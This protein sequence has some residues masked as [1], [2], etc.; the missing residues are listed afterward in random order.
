MIFSED[1]LQR[2]PSNIAVEI[3]SHGS[4]P[5]VESLLID[6]QREYMVVKRLTECSPADDSDMSAVY[7]DNTLQ[8]AEDFQTESNQLSIEDARAILNVYSMVQSSK[9]GHKDAGDDPASLWNLPLWVLCDGQDVDKTFMIG[10]NQNLDGGDNRLTITSV[11]SSGPFEKDALPSMDSLRKSVSLSADDNITSKGYAEYVVF[12]V[13]SLHTKTKEDGTPTSSIT[14][15]WEWPRVM[16]LLETP[17]G[18]QCSLKI[19][20]G[21]GEILHTTPERNLRELELLKSFITALSSDEIYWPPMEHSPK[22]VTEITS[23][24]LQDLRD[25]PMKYINEKYVETFEEEGRY[26]EDV[27]G[28]RFLD[29]TERI[30]LIIAHNATCYDD[31]TA[32]LQLVEDAFKT[33]YLQPMI[34]QDNTSEMANKIR[35]YY[36][37]TESP[38]QWRTFSLKHV[39]SLELLISI[40]LD[41]IR[42]DF[43]TY[44]IANSLCLGHQ[45][46]WYIPAK[47]SSMSLKEQAQR[48]KCLHHV[49][50]L[51]LLTSGFLKPYITSNL[52]LVKSAIQHYQ[53]N[54]AD[55]EYIVIAPAI[56]GELKLLCQQSRNIPSQ[57]RVELKGVGSLE[58]TLIVSL[59]RNPLFTQMEKIQQ[60][61][62]TVDELQDEETV[63][64][65]ISRVRQH[66][67]KLL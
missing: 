47:D 61:D 34:H 51:G 62:S 40:G 57:W 11:T 45:L 13:V 20:K 26:E 50:E 41:K 33:G 63:S 21:E 19:K 66:R 12:S 59:S 60:F 4:F 46:T 39:N 58:Q 6:V 44:L 43:S 38:D 9:K 15:E 7:E 23:T 48:L 54:P 8:N 3:Y 17:H 32:A 16:D 55:E 49:V 65:Y 24:Y 1:D 42:R 28:K 67:V 5:S 29:F 37:N 2:L 14:M 30:W 56:P 36:F 35:E 27:L 31:V 10:C 52:D 18:L 53:T 25:N 64:Y 22:S